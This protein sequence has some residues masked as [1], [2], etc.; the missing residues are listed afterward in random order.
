MRFFFCPTIGRHWHN[1]GRHSCGAKDR[2]TAK[3][4][5]EKYKMIPSLSIIL[6]SRLLGTFPP[7]LRFIEKMASLL[8][9]SLAPN[10]HQICQIWSQKKHA[11]NQLHPFGLLRPRHGPHFPSLFWHSLSIPQKCACPQAYL[12]KEKLHK[13]AASS[14]YSN[15]M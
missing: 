14:M 6:L 15:N 12:W 10:K 1:A 8:L 3:M 11:I 7:Q 4:F 2:M 5:F 9:I 13:L